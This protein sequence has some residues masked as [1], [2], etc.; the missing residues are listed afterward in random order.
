MTVNQDFALFP[1]DVCFLCDAAVVPDKADGR[2]GHR[3]I[4]DPRAEAG[5]RAYTYAAAVLSRA[6]MTPTKQ[7]RLLSVGPAVCAVICK[8]CYTKGDK[9]AADKTRS[10]SDSGSAGAAV[11][12]PT[13]GASR[14][15]VAASGQVEPAP[16]RLDEMDEFFD[17]SRFT[18]LSEDDGDKENVDH[19]TPSTETPGAGPAGGVAKAASVLKRSDHRDLFTVCVVVK[20]AGGDE[21]PLRKVRPC[22]HGA[23]MH[24]P[25]C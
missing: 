21:S 1:A 12:E 5:S 7:S 25:V 13:E 24:G 18:G 14:E 6:S 22:G 16:L 2:H 19:G 10:P 11:N 4:V 15:E 3:T 17:L 9:A 23:C 8:P 20:Q